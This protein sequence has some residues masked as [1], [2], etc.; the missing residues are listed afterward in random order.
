MKSARTRRVQRAP[1]RLLAIDI[2]NTHTV[3]GVFAGERLERLW[4]IT[5]GVSRTGD[6]LGALVEVLCRPYI[7]PIAGGGSVV[8]A[9]VVP[10]L[11]AE[12]EAMARRL[13]GVE[14]LVVSSLTPSGVRVELTDPSSV[15]ADRIANAAAVARG[16]LPAIVVDLGT[17]TTFDVIRPG[18]RY[19][20]GLIAPGVRTSADELFRRA[21]RLAKVEIRKPRR[22]IGRTTEES[23]Q[24]GVYY[25]A[26]GAIDGIIRRLAAELRRPARVLATG[27][28]ARLVAAGSETIQ[29]VDEALTLR[30]LA[31]IHRL[32]RESSRESRASR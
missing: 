9:S 11:T 16:P 23:I 20:G 8:V 18:R 15:G 26:I 1:A 30:G 28:L 7:D 24:A 25:G 27:G 6:E 5:S 22:L 14:P 3:L 13:F 12:Y 10:A 21:A 32:N 2:G 29:E 31:R 17:A 19:A 4:R